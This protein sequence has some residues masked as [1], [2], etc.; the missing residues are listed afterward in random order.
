[1]GKKRNR[2]RASRSTKR[3]KLH[4]LAQLIQPRDLEPS[5]LREAKVRS[6]LPVFVCGTDAT[7]DP[8][9]PTNMGR[10]ARAAIREAQAHLG[11]RAAHGFGDATTVIIQTANGWMV[12]NR[13]GDVDNFLPHDSLTVKL[14][15]RAQSKRANRERRDSSDQAALAAILKAR[16]LREQ[17]ERYAQDVYVAD[18]LCHL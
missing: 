3:V 12:R 7:V 16:A 11:V 5:F 15:E 18:M 14:D 13:H 17:R 9:N 1:M 4:N 2:N 8:D 6:D 10:I